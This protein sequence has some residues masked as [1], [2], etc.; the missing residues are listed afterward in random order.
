M[1]EVVFSDARQKKHGVNTMD[2]AKRLIDYGFHPY[3][4]AF[5]LIV[6]GGLVIEP[7]ESESTEE[8]D[9][10]IHAMQSMVEEEASTPDW[11]RPAPQYSRVKH[12]DEFGTRLFAVPR[13]NRARR[14]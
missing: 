6:P 14:L 12:R 3:T 7:T 1:H 13:R 9:R 5:P 10:F 4:T 11:V 8:G 2:I